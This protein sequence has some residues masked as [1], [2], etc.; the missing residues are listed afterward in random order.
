MGSLEVA[1]VMGREARSMWRETLELGH[2][3]ARKGGR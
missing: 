3:R 2:G 1:N